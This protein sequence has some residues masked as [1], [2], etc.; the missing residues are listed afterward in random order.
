MFLTRKALPPSAG[1]AVAR[2]RAC[3]T[4]CASAPARSPAA[5]DRGTTSSST[6]TSTRCGG[7]GGRHVRYPAETP[8]AN[9]HLTLLD[10]LGVPAESLGHATGPLPLGGGAG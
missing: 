5:W 2:T 10:R 7:P 4:R 6:S 9:L 3:S 8:L 1:R